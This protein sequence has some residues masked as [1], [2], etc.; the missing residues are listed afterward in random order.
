MKSKNGSYTLCNANVRDM[1]EDYISRLS[2]I[3]SMLTEN[4][5]ELTDDEKDV[6][7]PAMLPLVKDLNNDIIAFYLQGNYA[8]ADMAIQ[9]LLHVIET[10]T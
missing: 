5:R 7:R 1:I 3:S 8:K 4:G 6:I 2:A 10:L 9:D